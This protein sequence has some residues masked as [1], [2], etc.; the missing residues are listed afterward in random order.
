[1]M[2]R[3]LAATGQLGTGFKE[4]SLRAALAMRPDFIGC[5]AGSTD[6]GPYYLGAGVCMASRVA[7]RRDLRLLLRAGR[8]T[9]RR[10]LAVTRKIQGID[11]TN[12]R[13]MIGGMLP[14]TRRAAPAVDQH[15]RRPPVGHLPIG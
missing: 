2:V 8:S 3:A 10:C 13:E 1:M 9:P 12:V 15:E 6:P 7:I 11:R 4:E 5:D 14:V